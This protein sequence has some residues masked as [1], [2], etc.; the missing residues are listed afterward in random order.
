[1]I[2]ENLKT[3]SLKIA[4]AILLYK[5]EI[6]LEELKAL[7]FVDERDAELIAQ[8]LSKKFNLKVY[9]RKFRDE[10]NEDILSLIK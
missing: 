4:E 1:M 8:H 6:S 9:T 10:S 5:G 7:P 2:S 3:I